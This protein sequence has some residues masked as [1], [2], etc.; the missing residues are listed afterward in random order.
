MSSYPLDRS[1]TDIDPPRGQCQICKPS[2]L[3]RKTLLEST[4]RAVRLR[5]LTV[6]RDLLGRGNLGLGP[7]TQYKA[8]PPDSY[9]FPW[10][11]P[12]ALTQNSTLE[13]QRAEPT[14][15]SQKSPSTNNHPTLPASYTWQPASPS[16]SS[17]A[18]PTTTAQPNPTIKTPILCAVPALHRLPS[19]RQ[20]HCLLM[21]TA[22]AQAHGIRDPL[23][24]L[25]VMGP[26]PA[27][28]PNLSTLSSTTFY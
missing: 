23:P 25:G 14:Q 19:P 2:G 16:P 28:Q 13:P 6:A 4:G 3:Q 7:L 1:M 20:Q 11:P 10:P 8:A 17:S 24:Q 22:H 26:T 12:A 9:P 18:Q 15:P 5:V 27:R 21:H